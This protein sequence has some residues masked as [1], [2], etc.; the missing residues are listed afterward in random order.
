MQPELEGGDDA[1]IAAAAADG[2]EEVRIFTLAGVQQPAVCGGNFYGLQVV[3]G[4]TELAHQPSYATA[5]GQS[6]DASVGGGAH[7]GRQ[8]NGLGGAVHLPEQ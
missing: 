8:P 1:E 6:A 4:Q 7:G 5:R 3:D 2:P